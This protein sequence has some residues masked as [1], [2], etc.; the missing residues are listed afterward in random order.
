MVTLYIPNG[1]EAFEKRLAEL[2]P[3]EMRLM[4]RSIYLE[5]YP[6]DDLELEDGEVFP[7]PDSQG[8]IAETFSA[9]GVAPPLKSTVDS[10]QMRELVEQAFTHHPASDSENIEGVDVFFEHGQWWVRV[11]LETDEDDRGT[12]TYSVV[13]AEPGIAG[14]DFE[15]IE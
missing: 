11:T 8:G 6:L 2:T 5:L 15:E 4:L 14:F 9:F 12:K 1:P 7:R 3:D 13:D 10:A